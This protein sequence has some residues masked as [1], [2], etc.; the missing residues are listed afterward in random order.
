M[1]ADNHVSLELGSVDATKSA[2]LALGYGANRFFVGQSAQALSIRGASVAAD[3]NLLPFGFNVSGQS[4]GRV[5][6]GDGRFVVDAGDGAT[7]AQG[8]L[9]VG[10]AAVCCTN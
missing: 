10:G 7:A 4:T 9:V 5:T 1:S 2:T 8:N 3:I 6:V